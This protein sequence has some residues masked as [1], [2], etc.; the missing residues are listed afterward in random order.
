M[1]GG[2]RTHL[3][4]LIY[5]SWTCSVKRMEHNMWYV[6]CYRPPRL[7]QNRLTA[8]G[9]RTRAAVAQPANNGGLELFLRDPQ[10]HIRQE[11]TWLTSTGMHCGTSAIESR[12]CG[13]IFDIDDKQAKLTELERECTQSGF[14]D[15]ANAARAVLKQIKELKRVVDPWE[16][17]RGDADDLIE[18]YEMASAEDDQQTLAELDSQS[19]TLEK[20]I[21]RLEFLRKL[22]GPDDA[23]PAVLTVHSGAGGTE[24]CDWAEMLLRMYVR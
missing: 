2:E 23:A 15:D 22:G 11:E 17:V 19:V 9:L 16:K 5:R 13:G 3:R 6:V 10:T 14:W 21:A 18:L 1:C 8:P 12:T 7:V 24:S 4:R 20:A